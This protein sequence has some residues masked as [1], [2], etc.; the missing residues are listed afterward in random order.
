M[1]LFWLEYCLRL[2]ALDS[3]SAIADIFALTMLQNLWSDLLAS[4][5]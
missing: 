2:R 5:C 1:G 4:E 3:P